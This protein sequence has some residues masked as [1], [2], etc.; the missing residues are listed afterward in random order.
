MMSYLFLQRFRKS[1]TAIKWQWIFLPISTGNTTYGVQNLEYDSY[2]HAVLMAVYRGT[3]PKY[4]NYDL[5]MLDMSVPPKKDRLLGMNET[6]EILS[7]KRIG[8]T[9]NNSGIYGW[10]FPYGATGLY[11]FGNGEWLISENQNTADGQCAYIRKYIW[12]AIHPF[13]RK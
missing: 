12:D 1:S 9:E 3:K 5:F 13:I 6:A 2:T 7:L 10:H 11:S 4:Q 8:N